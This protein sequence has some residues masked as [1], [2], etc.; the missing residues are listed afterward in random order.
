MS[1]VFL[2]IKVKHHGFDSW[3]ALIINKVSRY[4][5]GTTSGFLYPS[6]SY[7]KSEKPANREMLSDI[8]RLL[9]DNFKLSGRIMRLK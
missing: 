1:F 4:D 3:G 8:R 5:A 9:V 2:L 7:P 6:D